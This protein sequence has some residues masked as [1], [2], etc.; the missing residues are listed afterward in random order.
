MFSV[1]PDLENTGEKIRFLMV[2]AD[3]PKQK[4]VAATGQK[5]G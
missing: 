3:R 2:K 1:A 4:A 5:P